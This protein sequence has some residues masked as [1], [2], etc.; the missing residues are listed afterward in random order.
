MVFRWSLIDSNSPQVFRTLL[1]ILADFNKAVVWTVSPRPVISKSSN[2]FINHLMIVLRAPITIGVIATFMFDSFFFQLP[3]KVGVL[4]SH[5]TFFQFYSVVH[6][7]S[8][9]QN[10]ASSFFFFYWFLKGPVVWPR[11]DDWFLSQN[12]RGVCLCHSPG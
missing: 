4:I 5:F 10:P 7:D 2:P 6:W 9:V 8:R 12:P 3:S 11:L 1:S